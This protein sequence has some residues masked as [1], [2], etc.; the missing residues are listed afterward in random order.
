MMSPEDIR[1][2]DRGDRI[3]EWH[4]L[5]CPARNPRRRGPFESRSQISM[6]REDGAGQGSPSLSAAACWARKCS[7]G[8]MW[9]SK[10][11]WRTSDVRNSCDNH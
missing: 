6:S 7:K 10:R 3:V 5:Q 8:D 1:L 2:A 11:A 9:L 4:E